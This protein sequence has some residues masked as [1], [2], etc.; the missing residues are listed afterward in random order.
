MGAMPKL[1]I[2]SNTEYGE[3][4]RPVWGGGI[5]ELWRRRMKK[6]NYKK[7]SSNDIGN[8]YHLSKKCIFAKSSIKKGLYR[9]LSVPSNTDKI[10]K[11]LFYNEVEKEEA[12]ILA[13]DAKNWNIQLYEDA[14]GVRY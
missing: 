14:N 12:G 9:L 13:N 6:I 3:E 8:I 5:W 7:L 4:P 10:S 1:Y 2:R 11:T